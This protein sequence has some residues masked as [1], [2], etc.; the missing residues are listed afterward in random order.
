[1]IFTAN[2]RASELKLEEKALNLQ[3]DS[4]GFFFLMIAVLCMPFT[5]LYD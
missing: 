1:M 4:A 3:R 2:K 5:Q